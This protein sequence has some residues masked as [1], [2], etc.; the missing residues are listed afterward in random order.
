MPPPAVATASRQEAAARAA[1]AAPEE[2]PAARP[3]AR[4]EAATKTQDEDETPAPEYSA[5]QV[6][7]ALFQR[8]GVLAAAGD[9]HL[10]E[11]LPGF[12]HSPETLFKWVIRTPVAGVST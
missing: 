3:S 8:F 6:K 4:G 12:I 9:R 2:E 5:D 11:F 1:S 7:F 10:V